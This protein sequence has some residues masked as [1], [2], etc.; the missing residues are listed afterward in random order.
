VATYLLNQKREELFRLEKLFGLKIQI[1][2]HPGLSHH[3]THISFHRGEPPFR[4]E[5][6]P[7]EAKE[8][9]PPQDPRRTRV[10][11]EEADRLAI[12]ELKKE[13]KESFLKKFFWPP[14]LWREIWKPS[15][16]PPSSP[17]KGQGAVQETAEAPKKTE[18]RI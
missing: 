3:R 6:T 17:S 15:S 2:G 13:T 16:P 1:A 4:A 9:V 8:G 11:S 14:S 7:R 10:T 18:D 12:E 5:K